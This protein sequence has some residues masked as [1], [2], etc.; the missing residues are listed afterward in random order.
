MD[1][2]KDDLGRTWER[3]PSRRQ[4]QRPQQGPA[5]P[6]PGS[7]ALAPRTGEN[8]FLWLQPP[9]VAFGHGG[10]QTLTCHPSPAHWTAARG[11]PRLLVALATI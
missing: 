9:D 1:T 3:R 10:L 4:G 5:W 7:G 6:A 8:W 2:Q 11:T